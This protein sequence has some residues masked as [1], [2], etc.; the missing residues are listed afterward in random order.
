MNANG[1]GRFYNDDR[2][3]HR[4][5]RRK[6]NTYNYIYTHSPQK[7]QKWDEKNSKNKDN[8]IK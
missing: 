6:K 3:K 7:K 4:T 1:S 2:K 5:K 8:K